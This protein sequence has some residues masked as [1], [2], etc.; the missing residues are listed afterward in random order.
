[1][2]PFNRSSGVGAPDPAEASTRTGAVTGA[3]DITPRSE[4]RSSSSTADT[5]APRSG[6]P[7]RASSKS[8]E[9]YAAAQRSSFSR[10]ETSPFDYFFAAEP[11]PPNVA[12]A[13]LRVRQFVKPLLEKE[14]LRN[15]RVAIVTA[16]G[17]DV[18]LEVPSEF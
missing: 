2:L 4:A 17:T 9:V 7:V 15:V 14:H 12:T 10:S 11:P 16:G 18:P 13:G 6:V 5:S 8:H 3:S 1:M